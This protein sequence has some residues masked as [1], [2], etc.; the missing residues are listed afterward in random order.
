MTQAAPASLLAAGVRPEQAAPENRDLGQRT[1]VL[2]GALLAMLLAA[3]DQN[4]VN[5]ALPRIVAD[6]GGIAH[7][8]WVVTSFMLCS[9]VTAPLYGKLSDSYGRR[10]MFFVA[11]LLF[12]AASLLCG[13]ARSMAELVG[14]RALQGLGAGGLLVLAQAAIGDV[15]TPIERPRYQGLFVG[16]FALASV[17]GPVLGGVITQALSWRWIFYVNLPP[18]LA[19]LLMIGAGLRAPPPAAR[20][21]VDYG[22]AL[23]LAGF[24]MALLLLLSWG[25][26]RFAWRSGDAAGLA[27][28]AIMLAALFIRRERRAPDPLIRLGLFGNAV[29]ARSVATGAALT[30]ALFGSIV[31]LPLYFQHVFKMNPALAGTMMLPQ[32]LG[33]LLSSIGSGRMVARLGRA[34]PFLLAGVAL[35]ALALLSLA[36]LAALAAPPWPFLVS[37]AGL[38]LGIGLAMPNLTNTVQN[39]VAYADLGA[40]TGAMIFLRS[41]GGAAGVAASGALLSHTLVQASGHAAIASATRLGLTHGFLLCSAVAGASLVLV[42]GLADLRLRDHHG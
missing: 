28:L 21:P 29:F 32:V 36:G 3:L 19:A 26:S 31:F 33:M 1:T 2:A 41:L 38:G 17:A 30:F 11:I 35:V 7:L 13:Q 23:L 6:L 20:R 14:F 18:G 5:T 27:A 37:M 9:T 40:A 10:R 16:T 42:S 4:I 39:A 34:K 24:T 8:S 12:L 25:G 22:G 15:V